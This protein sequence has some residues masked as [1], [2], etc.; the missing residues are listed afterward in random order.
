MTREE[1]DAGYDGLHV[2]LTCENHPNMRWSCKKIAISFDK[3]G[4]GRYNQQR[5]IFFSGV[6]DENGK[7]DDTQYKEC[8]CPAS[9]LRLIL[10]EK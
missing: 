9:N 2:P 8:N 10:E 1:F 3:D 5:S 4:V 7:Y 6:L